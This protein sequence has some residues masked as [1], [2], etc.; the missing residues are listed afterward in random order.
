MTEVKGLSKKTNIK[1]T[2]NPRIPEGKGGEGEEG[3]V[4][5]EKW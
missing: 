4:G 5:G 1:E 3:K 2:T